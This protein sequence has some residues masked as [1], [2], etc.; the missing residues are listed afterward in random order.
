VLTPL[1]EKQLEDRAKLEGTDVEHEKFKFLTEKQ[2]MAQ[3]S[4]AE[5]I[6][7]LAAFL[8]SDD[9]RT[10]TGTPIS[11]DGGWVAH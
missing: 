6:G 3:F 5:E 10:I 9:A 4:T 7:A 1:V 8:C 11:V 2:A